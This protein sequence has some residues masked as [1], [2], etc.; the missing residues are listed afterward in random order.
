MH[1][2]FFNELPSLILY[3]NANVTE[4]LVF[5][6]AKG[7]FPMMKVQGLAF[8]S[9]VEGKRFLPLLFGLACVN[10]LIE[11][12]ESHMTRPSQLSRCIYVV[13]GGNYFGRMTSPLFQCREHRIQS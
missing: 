11:T 7:N 1:N 4:A 8:C 6:L 10:R 2:V 3:Q 13:E 5:G 12:K 9:I